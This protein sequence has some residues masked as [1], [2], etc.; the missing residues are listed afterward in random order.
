MAVPEWKGFSVPGIVNNELHNHC[1]AVLAEKIDY[2]GTEQ[3][4][5]DHL[6]H[7]ERL[8]DEKKNTGQSNHCDPRDS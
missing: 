2:R 8:Q 3:E 6:K 4:F 1:F 7:L 5:I